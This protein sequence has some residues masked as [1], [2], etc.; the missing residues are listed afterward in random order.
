MEQVEKDNYFDFFLFTRW[1]NVVNFDD[2]ILRMSG[3]EIYVSLAIEKV[4]TE[5]EKKYVDLSKIKVATKKHK[6]EEKEND[7]SDG[8]E[9]DLDEFGNCITHKKYLFDFGEMDEKCDYRLVFVWRDIT[10]EEWNYLCGDLR[11]KPD[12]FPSYEQF[13]V[14]K[15]EAKYKLSNRDYNIGLSFS[16]WNPFHKEETKTEKTDAKTMLQEFAETS[17]LFKLNS[18][19]PHLKKEKQFIYKK[20]RKF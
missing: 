18:A 20:R 9:N 6:R 16:F 8:L 7:L 3:N 19:S 5:Q 1:V 12:E 15:N 2:S 11:I 14:M 13:E 4:E 10:K 17:D